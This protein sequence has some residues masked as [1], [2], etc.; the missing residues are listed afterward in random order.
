MICR[1]DGSR[2]LEL[3]AVKGFARV[4]WTLL[5]HGALAVPEWMRKGQPRFPDAPDWMIQKCS[6]VTN[7]PKKLRYK[8]PSTLHIPFGN[9]PMA[10]VPYASEMLVCN[11]VRGAG[12]PW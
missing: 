9:L 8:L 5:C 12:S 2:A 11:A 6:R 7:T 10:A 3:A 4:G 1:V